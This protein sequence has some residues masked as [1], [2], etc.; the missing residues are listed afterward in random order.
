MDIIRHY[1]NIGLSDKQL[2][3]LVNGKAKIVLYPEIT[4]YKTLDQL[5]YPYDAVFLLYESRPR[6]GHW[7]LVHK[8]SKDT[9]ECFDPYGTVIDDQLYDIE[10]SFRKASKQEIPWL[11]YL[12]YHS[13]Y[14]IDYNE[15]QF[16]SN[17]INVKTCGR[18]CVIRLYYSFLTLSQ[19]RDLFLNDYGDAIVTYLTSWVNQ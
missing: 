7:N 13:P 5:L 6:W 17:S 4:K 10:P 1:E 16:Q 8:I 3:E 11:S 2:L 19:F 9:V 12:L 15:Y 14:N 18:W